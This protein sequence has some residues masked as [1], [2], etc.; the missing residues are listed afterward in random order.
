MPVVH[1]DHVS[2]SYTSA[3]DVLTDVTL[4]LGPG[5]CGLVGPNGAGKTTLLNL[6]AGFISPTAGTVSVEPSSPRPILC[7]QAVEHPSGA[8]ADFV[9]ATDGYARRWMGMLGL[10]PEDFWRWDTLSPGERK[11]WQVG[12]ALA[13]EPAVL[14]LDEP[15]NHLDAAAREVLVD[16]IEQFRGVG[17]VVSHDRSLLNRLTTQTVVV[18]HAAA[19]LWGGPYDVARDARRAAARQQREAYEG[20][21]REQ[22]KQK[23][24]LADQRRA[25]ETKQARQSRKL[26]LAGPAD[27]DARSMEAKGRFEA[28]ATA[29]AR[30]MEVTKAALQRAESRAAGFEMSGE[31][32]RSLFI[33]Y[34]PARRSRILA[35]AGPLVAGEVVVAEHVDVELQRDDRVRLAGANGAGKT[36][37]LQALVAGSDLPE[38]RLL[39]LPQELTEADVSAA[40]S[41]LHALSPEE[42][43]KVLNLVA[44]LGVDPDRLLVSDDPSPGEA[45]KLAMAGG[46]ALSAWCVLLDEPTNHLDLPSVE[47]LEAAIAAFPGAVLIV[48]HDDDFAAATTSRSWTIA[49]GALVEEPR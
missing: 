19:A 45:R 18:E 16:S 15:T 37:L 24:R 12:A 4:H 31:L 2:F 20:A 42:K 44:A 26:R 36:T 46:L 27:K 48:T 49:D 30:R 5:W 8:I 17:V 14:L 7:S 23:R 41:R 35:Y 32:G 40:L 34:D 38:E 1:L 39:Y 29:G 6:I 21:V 43:G 47:R 9:A 10:R 33:D 11:R 13:A 25:A 22:K 28:G 3:A